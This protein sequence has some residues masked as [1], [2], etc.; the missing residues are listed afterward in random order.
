MLSDDT[1]S[2][3]DVPAIPVLCLGIL[4]GSSMGLKILIIASAYKN[5]YYGIGLQL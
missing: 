4:F 1:L 2:S 5:T 3:R